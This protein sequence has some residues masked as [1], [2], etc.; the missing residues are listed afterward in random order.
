MTSNM[1][2][3]MMLFCA[4]GVLVIP[5]FLPTGPSALASQSSSLSSEQ[6]K[7]LYNAFYYETRLLDLPTF[8]YQRSADG[9]ITFAA[10]LYSKDE[11]SY[12]LLKEVFADSDK[13]DLLLASRRNNEVVSVLLPTIADNMAAYLQDTRFLDSAARLEITRNLLR[14]LFLS[15]NTRSK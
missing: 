8:G 5:A 13:V 2:K 3:L 4:L 7:L 15:A 11:V 9:E 1:R 10:R 14:Y 12:V 6:Q